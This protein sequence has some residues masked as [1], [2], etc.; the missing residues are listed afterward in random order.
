VGLLCVYYALD[1]GQFEKNL[2]FGKLNGNRKELKEALAEA[3]ISPLLVG[4]LAN[5]DPAARKY[6]EWTQKTCEQTGLRFELRECPRVQL[7]DRVVEAN[8][9]PTVHG[10]MIY[11]P[12]FGGT[13]DQYLQNTVSVEKDVEGLS[14]LYRY[15]MYHNIRFLDQAETQK[16]IIPCTPLAIVKV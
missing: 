5:D 14:H 9:D 13:Q 11:Y 12:V 6:A 15:N 3:H 8:Q 1:P 16:C 7:E 4:F 10:I 2:N